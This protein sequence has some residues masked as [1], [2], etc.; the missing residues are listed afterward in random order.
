MEVAF[1]TEMGFTGKVPRTHTNMRTEFAWMVASNADHY[2]INQIPD[3][4]YDLG[5][6]IITSIAVGI[7][8]LPVVAFCLLFTMFFIGVI[9]EFIKVCSLNIYNKFIVYYNNISYNEIRNS[10]FIYCKK[11]SYYLSITLLSISLSWGIGTV[12]KKI[13]GI[14]I[15]N[16]VHIS[17][18]FSFMTSTMIGFLIIM[19][20]TIGIIII[21]LIC[22][23]CIALSTGIND[24]NN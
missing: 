5:I 20:V 14:C 17:N 3:K 4:R 16:C 24:S 22:I 11:I 1:F 18:M 9:C 8:G 10:S 19:A 6:T 7:I 21:G 15:W 2:N 12:Y 13:I 23:C